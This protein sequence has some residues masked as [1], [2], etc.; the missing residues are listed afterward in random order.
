MGRARPYNAPMPDELQVVFFQDRH[1]VGLGAVRGAGPKNSVLI[2]EQGEVHRLRHSRT[3]HVLAARLRSDD[4]PVLRERLRALRREL[5]AGAE[6][7]DMALLDAALTDERRY[8][9]GELATLYFGDASDQAVARLVAALDGPEGWITAGLRVEQGE[10]VRLDA[11]TRTRIREQRAREAEKR[12]Q[13]DALAAWWEPRRALPGGLAEAPDDPAAQARLEALR[14]YAL[15]GDQA[16]EA[17][18]SRHL[19]RRLGLDGPDAVLA[20]LERGGAVP[21]HVNEAP[22]RL[23]LPLE[24][25][26]PVLAAAAAPAPAPAGEDL[27]GRF[28]VAIDDPETRE[29][30][31]AL[32]AWPEGDDVWVAVHIARLTELVAPDGPLDR[33]ALRRATSVYFAEAVVPML[34]T[35]LGDRASLVAGEDRGAV[36]LVA[37]IT[38]A[39][40]VAE[41]RFTTSVVRVGARL[42]YD[43]EPRGEAA[44]TLEP[45]VRAAA[46]LR[47]ARRRRGAVLLSLPQLKMRVGP[48][49]AP[50][51]KSTRVESSSHLAVSELM[52]LF[53]AQL[54]R[55]LRE[56][57]LP[58][59]FRTQPKAVRPP[60]HDPADPLY[61]PL[62]R[63]GL[64]PTIVS[65]EPGPHRMLGVDAYVQGTSPIRR[66]SDLL[67]QRQLVAHLA[68]AP[69]PYDR[70]AME[71]LKGG[72]EA[73]EK[74]AQRAMDDR[75][76]Y[77]LVEWFARRVEPLHAVVSR[78]DGRGGLTVYVPEVDRELPLREPSPPPRPGDRLLVRVARAAPRER[79]VTLEA[80]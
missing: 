75:E 22:H 19:A 8:T 37:R 51:V 46:A 42:A 70:A 57:S 18:W 15:Q 59:L 50:Q 78:V 53:N 60:A 41:A 43:E 77:W 38:P 35:A 28:A 44:A 12:R 71:R 52:I 10:V 45:A 2:D 76:R 64:P 25:G 49:G 27:R 79:S 32:A 67:A 6:A 29:V 36:S 17:A 48:D 23:G 40:D 39:G 7:L 1:G 61:A 9:L 55:A 26:E 24:F 33:E 54:G 14:A 56:A 74:R 80:L 72:V 62:C 30:D 34:P 69:A 31:D 68:G 20:A 73:A 21:A 3:L 13:E 65:V 16:P 4:P 66:V 5:T 11:E 63:R 47:E 58:A